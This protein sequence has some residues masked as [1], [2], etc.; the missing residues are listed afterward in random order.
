MP[1]HIREL[2]AQRYSRREVLKMGAGAAAVGFLAPL[3]GC[4]SSS[5]A[6]SSA[7][8]GFKGVPVSRQ[9][10]VVV[11]AGYKAVPLYSWGDPVSDGPA[12][13]PN[14][15]QGA[16]E[17]ILQAGDNHDGMHFFSL[18]KGSS[19]S[20]RGLLVMNHEYV[21]P[22]LHPNGPSESP[23]PLPE[24]QKEQAAHGV[25]VIEVQRNDLN[26]WQVVRPSPFARRLTANT[27]MRIAGPAAGHSKMRT[28]DDPA[29]TAVLGTL[30]NCAHGFT[31]WG[32]YLTCEENWDDYFVNTDETD[33]V[34]RREHA[35]YT[36]AGT[37][38]YAWHDADPRFDATPPVDGSLGYVNETN[39]F[40]WVVEFD[41]FD[42]SSVPVKRTALG[43]F[44]H[45]NCSFF[46]DRNGRMAFYMGDDA[47]GE[48]I[49][50]FVPEAVV[51]PGNPAANRD[52]LDRG[53]LYVARLNE[54]GSGRWIALVHGE[55][56]LTPEAGYADQGDVLINTRSAADLVGATPM[57]RPEWVTIN[58]A[59]GDAYVTLTNNSNRGKPD[60]DPVDA[61]NPR[62]NNRY[63]HI[64]HLRDAN[65]DSTA[66]EFSWEIFVLAGDPASATVEMRGNVQGDSFGSPDGLWFDYFGR[67]WIQTDYDDRDALYANL[68]NCQMLAADPQTREIRRFLVGPTGCEVTGVITTPDGT[69]MFVNIQ[70]PTGSF[71]A[72]DGVTR[73]RSTTMVITHDE[74]RVVGS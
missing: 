47:R 36:V 15:S 40:G 28:V 9:D 70:H 53:T 44:S 32:T 30:N 72:S 56:G 14:A 18:P 54:D 37:S 5:G 4:D 21:N 64:V 35:R 20:S 8:L 23:R 13:N 62:A 11:A 67:L 12:W 42:P 46:T 2:I 74:G 10:G 51:D 55:N 63:G 59:T 60:N 49:Y 71:P 3:A 22:P 31:P 25:S 73:P 69:A 43:R 58:P 17:Q 24:V 68:G 38:E 1:L 41:P 65:A 34:A 29:G 27:P 52:L 48:Y 57:D 7:L 45:E 33:R 50:K 39:R 66:T 6:R 61:A 16:A 26:Q 19:N